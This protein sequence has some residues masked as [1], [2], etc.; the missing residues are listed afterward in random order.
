M[1]AAS[2]LGYLR[3]MLDE[4]QAKLDEALKISAHT[5]WQFR[6]LISGLMGGKEVNY[7]QYLEPL[8]LLSK[9]EQEFIKVMKAL[10]KH[11]AKAEA[12]DNITK[13]QAIAD[14]G[15]KRGG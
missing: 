15:R 14:M 8:G 12:K 3:A 11:R 4:Q 6:N 9:Q 13:A 2:F 7:L 1:P 10:E 5:G